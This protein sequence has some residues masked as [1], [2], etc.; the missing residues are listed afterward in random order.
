MVDYLVSCG[1]GKVRKL[2]NYSVGNKVSLSKKVKIVSMV[3]EGK[4][5][6]S[7]YGEI[8]QKALLECEGPKPGSL[9]VDVTE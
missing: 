6:S 1:G 8:C 9:V 5:E 7:T 4:V 2:I 3:E